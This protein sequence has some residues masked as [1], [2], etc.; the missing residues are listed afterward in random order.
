MTVRI[1]NSSVIREVEYIP[2]LVVIT[3][4]SGAVYQYYVPRK[5]AF[6]NLIKAPSIGKYYNHVF[7]KHYGPGEYIG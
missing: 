7:K 5:R 6:T 1:S 4:Q 3:F 2:Y